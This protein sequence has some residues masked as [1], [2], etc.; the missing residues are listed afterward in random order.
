MKIIRILPFITFLI[1]YGCDQKSSNS[2]KEQTA[3]KINTPIVSSVSIAS[4][5][6]ELAVSEDKDA[7]PSAEELS[8]FIS[9]Q[10][11]ENV[12]WYLRSEF[13]PFGKTIRGIPV[14]KINP[15]WCKANEFKETLFLDDIPRADI[16]A[17]QKDGGTFS[18]TEKFDGVNQQTAL[19]GIYETCSH[20]TGTFLM[21]LQTEKSSSPIVF[22][23][24]YANAFFVYLL[25]LQK[26]RM[27]LADC[28]GCDSGA[29]YTWIDS[30][31]A[32][33]IA[34]KDEEVCINPDSILYS[35]ANEHSSPIYKTLKLE[36]GRVLSV[37]IRQGDFY[38]H[39]IKLGSGKVGF[40][41][42]STFNTEPGLCE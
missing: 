16:K 26:N 9:I 5:V 12:A 31:L 21:L 25:P 3:T 1:F 20:D 13:H 37:G 18:L 2:T 32:A 34:L 4:T 8:Q 36:V 30:S 19:V 41:L 17:I 28:Y 35:S 27:V 39:Q 38:W 29:I 15:N 33:N 14:E 23:K 24:E 40:V 10:A 6:N 42:N 7:I 22:L 11:G